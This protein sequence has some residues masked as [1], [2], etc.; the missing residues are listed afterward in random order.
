MESKIAVVLLNLGGPDKIENVRPFLY[1]LFSDKWIIRAPFIIRKLIAYIISTKRYK[2]ASENYEIMGGKSP[3]L[4]E[5]KKQKNSLKQ[6]LLKK[7]INAKIFIS[8]RYWHPLSSE[9]IKELEEYNPDEIILLPLY[10]QLSSST[11]ISSFEDFEKSISNSKVNAKIKK[12]GCYFDDEKFVESHVTLIKNEIKKFSEKEKENL[13]I[14]F[15][16]H[17]IPVKFV[18]QGDPYQWQ[19]EKTYKAILNDKEISNIENSLSY[20]SKVGPIEWLAPQ[21]E[22]VIRITAEEGKNM[23]IVPIAFV[24][25]H[26]ET[27]VELDVEYKEIADKLG[28]KYN[29]VPALTEDAKF[30]ECLSDMVINTVK[31]EDKISCF[32]SEKCPSNFKNC[33]CNI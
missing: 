13:K 6:S 17:S 32:R 18:T 7:G 9:V 23:I 30:I 22:D 3:L 11:T 20:Q 8:M 26:I 21:T 15:S 31:S 14:I 12:I 16:A 1:N 25:E 24:S 4:D 27:L 28:V 5:T 33:V 29:R 10:P 2:E 19:I